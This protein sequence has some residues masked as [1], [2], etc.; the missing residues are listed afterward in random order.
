[1]APAGQLSSQNQQ[2]PHNGSTAGPMPG[3]EQQLAQRRAGQ[4][5]SPASRA[6]RPTKE[7]AF[8]TTAVPPMSLP[9]AESEKYKA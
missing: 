6:G 8:T 3:G 4:G 7:G 1:M 9:R 5:H 2:S